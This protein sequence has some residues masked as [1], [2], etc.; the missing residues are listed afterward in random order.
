MND[1]FMMQRYY[2]LNISFHLTDMHLGLVLRCC[3]VRI[4]LFIGLV[5]MSL[6]TLLLYSLS[7]RYYLL[8]AVPSTRRHSFYRSVCGAL[9]SLFFTLLKVYDISTYT[10]WATTIGGTFSGVIFVLLGGVPDLLVISR[11][12]R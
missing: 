11:R 9:Y 6:I 5:Q 8:C 2:I 7:T 12:K 1:L 4:R 3:A 10:M